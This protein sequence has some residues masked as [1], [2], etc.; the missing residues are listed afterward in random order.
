[1]TVKLNRPVTRETADVDPIWHD[2]LMVR[3]E[4][5][6]RVLRVW[7]KGRRTRYTLTYADLW[8]WAYQQAARAAQADRLRERLARRKARR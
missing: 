4:A 1:M 2:R 5:G 7:R 3:L 8:R 6:G